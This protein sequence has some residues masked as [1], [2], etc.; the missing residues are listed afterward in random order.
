M[1]KLINNIALLIYIFCTYCV[2]ADDTIGDYANAI[3]KIILYKNDKFKV[4]YGGPIDNELGHD[5]VKSRGVQW[6]MPVI[7]EDQL[8]QT[9]AVYEIAFVNCS[10]D[11]AKDAEIIFVNVSDVDIKFKNQL[12]PDYKVFSELL[13]G[14]YS[15][16]KYIIVRLTDASNV[17]FPEIFFST[18]SDFKKAD[19][20]KITHFLHD[21]F[22]TK[23][24]F[25]VFYNN[26]KKNKILSENDLETV[27][28]TIP[29]EVS[30]NGIHKLFNIS[31]RVLKNDPWKLYYIISR[32]SCHLDAE[33]S[34][35][36]PVLL[37][38]DSGCVS[39]QVYND[40]SCDCLDQLHHALDQLSN[41]PA[42]RSLIIH[43]PMHDGRGFGFAPKAETEIYKRGGKG[44]VNCTHALDTLA[45]A[46]LLYRSSKIDLRTFDG[47]AKILECMKIKSVML[48][49]DNV[50]KVTALKNNNI[51]VLRKKTGTSKASCQ[52][53]INSKKNS[54]NYFK[55]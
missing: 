5:Q 3:E 32:D 35:E 37:R 12:T 17:Y 46:N 45:A 13:N 38:L 31:K 16:D 50:A 25:K 19:Q 51:E 52:A 40:S 10:I 48:L 39:G 24:T 18:E 28:Q 54:S 1:K 55:D 30:F 8:Y 36:L 21:H 29:V 44:R 11:D 49:T 34:I 15:D 23:S 27:Y 20:G 14:R 53:H 6:V 43:I 42:E 4:F 9:R 33:T 41:D 7:F 47:A 22:G 26:K 2:F